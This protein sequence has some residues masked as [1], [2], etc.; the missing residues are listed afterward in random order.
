MAQCPNHIKHSWKFVKN[1]IK[2]TE[3]LGAIELT[4]VGEYTCNYCCAEKIGNASHDAD[5][6]TLLDE[7]TSK[8]P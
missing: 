1:T 6:R 4:A 2:R 5:L 3:R 7:A 8:Q